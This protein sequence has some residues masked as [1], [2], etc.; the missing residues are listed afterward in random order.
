MQDFEKNGPC[1]VI[2]SHASGRETAAEFWASVILFIHSREIRALL[3]NKG[4]PA[5]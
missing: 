1:E 5:V 2:R 4:E 3:K